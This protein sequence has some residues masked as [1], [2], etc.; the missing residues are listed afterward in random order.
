MDINLCINHLGLN[1]NSYGLNQSNPPHEFIRWDGPDPQPTQEELEVA[2]AEAQ[3][4]LEASTAAEVERK[5]SAKSKLT[6][7]GLS[8]DEISAAFGI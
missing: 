5:A 7:L 1:R 6:A 4:V 8:E 3:Q 2:W